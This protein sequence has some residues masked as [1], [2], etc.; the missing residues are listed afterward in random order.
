[1]LLLHANTCSKINFN[2]NKSIRYIY[3]SMNDRNSHS[4]YFFDS[5]WQKLECYH[6][7]SDIPKH[8]KK[9]YWQK[10]PDSY[11]SW[12]QDKLRTIVVYGKSIKLY[13]RNLDTTLQTLYNKT[14]QWVMKN[15]QYQWDAK[16]KCCFYDKDTGEKLDLNQLLLDVHTHTFEIKTVNQ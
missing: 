11:S 2:P 13:V 4:A 5:G 15:K 16:N 10:E 6:K 3:D 8:I 1:M 9:I 12:G 14:H 7:F